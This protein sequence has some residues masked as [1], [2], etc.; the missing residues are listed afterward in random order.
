MA[1]PS[2]IVEATAENFRTLVL[3]N[4]EKGP[5]LVNYWSP[6]AGPCM[7][8]MPR[9]VRLA[10]EF[11]GW[12]LLT[13]LNTDEWGQLARDHGV[14]SIP[15]I[16]VFRYGKAVDTL[17]GAESEPALRRF[18][19]KHIERQSTSLHTAA[20]QA[21]QRGNIEQAVSLAAQAALAEPDNPSIPL[22]L[23][24]LLVLQHRYAQ[25]RDLL[26][27]LPDEMKTHADIRSLST[28]IDFIHTAQNS[29]PANELEQILAANPN[30]SAARFQLAALKL[31]ED[32][33]DEAMAQLL[34]IVR[35]KKSDQARTAHE[36]LLAI[37]RLLGED[38]SRVQ[39]Y[40][41]AL[42]DALH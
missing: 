11:G 41:T 37:F 1:G 5:V 6:Q 29:P 42:S 14:N 12:F 30:D 15:T 23:A 21:Q 38:D 7:M 34:E 39:H 9:L 31:T 19:D 8:L 36:G 18:I 22:D 20:V 33:Y 26:K 3:E 32:D 13:L 4:S 28:H 2:Y 10:N 25:A 17:H 24:K 16:K 35:R 40:R 27:A